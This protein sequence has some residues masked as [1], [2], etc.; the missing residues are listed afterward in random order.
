M[1]VFKNDWVR[2]CSYLATSVLETGFPYK[3]LLAR[4]VRPLTSRNS[5]VFPTEDL[6]TGGIC[7]GSCEWYEVNCREIID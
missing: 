6:T 3:I 2:W 5:S 7:N 1:G 4:C